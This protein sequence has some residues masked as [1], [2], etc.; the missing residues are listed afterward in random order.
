MLA[1]AATT[2]AL[3]ASAVGQT[4]AEAGASTRL[5]AAGEAGYGGLADDDFVRVVLRAGL[6]APVAALGCP[7]DTDACQT[8]LAVA[9]QAPLRLR[10][11]DRQPS[12]DALLRRTDWDEPTDFLRLLRHAVYGQPGEPLQ[13][14]LGELG[15]VSLGHETLVHDYYNVIDVDHYQL[16]AAVAADSAYG[17]FE[18]LADNVAAPEVVGARLAVR[19]LGLVDPASL[20]AR[21][22]LGTSVVADLEAPNRLVDTAEGGSAVG[23][24]RRLAVA[25][26]QT[27]TLVG[28]DAE[29]AVVDAEAFGLVPYVDYNHHVHLGSGVHAGTH[30]WGRP[31]EAIEV[32]AQ[33]EYRYLDGRYLPAYVGPLYEVSRFQFDG[34]GVAAAAPKLRVAASLPVEARQGG[35]GDLTV[36]W[37]DRLEV[38]A[39]YAQ[40]EGPD[41][42]S[43]RLRIA[44]QPFEGAQ[45]GV[46]YYKHSFGSF[47]EIGDLD[48]ALVVGES[49]VALW[50]PLYALGAYGQLWRVS[51]EGRYE[52]VDDWMVGLGAG[53]AFDLGE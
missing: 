17:S 12:Q 24:D 38:T 53:A 14:R 50:G 28:V 18:M 6:D 47:D 40:H 7:P 27:T 26:A 30:V 36:R 16:G 23:E 3:E 33:A 35:Y 46:F 41:N 43:V 25:Q 19:P 37:R 5:W 20:L 15:P 42:R 8:R 48:D 21:V 39:A 31:T 51:D 4:P 32:F 44:G 10:V 13:A 2:I 9:L 52:S 45:I 49:R 34:W 11:V 22:A 29:V 1:L